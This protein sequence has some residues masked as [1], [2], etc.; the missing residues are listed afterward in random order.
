MVLPSGVSIKP[1]IHMFTATIPAVT[2]SATAMT[3]CHN[4][5]MFPPLSSK[6]SAS[7]EFQS[8]PREHPLVNL[9]VLAVR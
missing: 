6:Y 7:R 3:L 9:D 2:T 5:D 4:P 8:D 1:T